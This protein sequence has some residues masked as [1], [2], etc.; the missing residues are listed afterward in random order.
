MTS[1]ETRKFISRIIAQERAKGTPIKQ[2]IRIAHDL[3]RVKGFDVSKQPKHL[4]VMKPIDTHGSQKKIT[5]YEEA[6]NL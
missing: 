1:R 3:A 4:K 5:F 2:A 6:H